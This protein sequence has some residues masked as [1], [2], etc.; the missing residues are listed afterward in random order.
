MYTSNLTS[1]ANN[2]SKLHSI[3]VKHL[4]IINNLICRLYDTL[5]SEML[6]STLMLMMT[7]MGGETDRKG[8]QE[9]GRRRMMRMITPLIK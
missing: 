1:S 4:A 7:M 2:N 8:G 9:M 3:E 6:I 5:E